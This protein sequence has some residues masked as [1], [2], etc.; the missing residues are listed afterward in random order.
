M[1]LNT[2]DIP[3]DAPPGRRGRH[4]LRGGPTRDSRGVPRII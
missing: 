2:H 1:L 3:G 4:D